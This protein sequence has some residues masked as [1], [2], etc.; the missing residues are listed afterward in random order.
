MF[1]DLALKL[2][3]TDMSGAATNCWDAIDVLQIHAYAKT[4]QDVKDKIRKYYDVFRDDFEGTNGRKKKV[5]W[6]TEVAMGSANG[7]EVAGFVRDLM[8]EEDGLA[9]RAAAASNGFGFV[10]RVS[11]FSEFFFPAFNVS[12]VPAAPMESWSSSL[13]NPFG[14]LS[15]VGQE[16]FSHC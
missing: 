7:T 4:A 11:W 16:F 13:F 6:L 12:G 1:K 15:V 8:N 2:S 10:E 5:L 14:D 9:N 3:C